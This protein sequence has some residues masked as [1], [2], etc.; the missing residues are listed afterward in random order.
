MP[1]NLLQYF[2]REQG[3]S[4]E[5]FLSL[6]CKLFIV[7]GHVELKLCE[8]IFKLCILSAK[9]FWVIVLNVFVEFPHKV[10]IFLCEL[11]CRPSALGAACDRHY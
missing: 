10:T 9:G 8:K 7:K 6:R 2:S 5:Y 1:L 11:G 3:N 4:S